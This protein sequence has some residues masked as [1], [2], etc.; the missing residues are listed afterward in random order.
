M[1]SMEVAFHIILGLILGTIYL[2]YAKQYPAKEDLLWKWGL[3]IAAF[4]YI[5]FALLWG[6]LEWVAIEIAGVLI[7]G[8][9]YLL[10]NKFGLTWIAAGWLLHPIWDIGLHWYGAG[11]HIGPEWYTIPCL[12]FDILVG[13]YILVRIGKGKENL[14]INDSK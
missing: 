4:I 3:V 7:Y 14:R 10:S 12:S 6:D 8:L 9:F 2:S 11:S 13:I 5:L 1:T